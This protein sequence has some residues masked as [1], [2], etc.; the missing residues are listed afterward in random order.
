MRKR[1]SSRKQQIGILIFGIFALT[2]GALLFLKVSSSPNQEVEAIKNKQF[3]DFLLSMPQENGD[4]RT[5]RLDY[6][7]KE[8]DIDQTYYHLLIQDRLSL[9]ID[10]AKVKS[11]FEK[12]ALNKIKDDTYN[13][14][15]LSYI[16]QNNKNFKV[17]PRVLD[18]INQTYNKQLKLKLDEIN[19]E[20][21]YY[22]SKFKYYKYDEKNNEIIN[23]LGN[24]IEKEKMKENILVLTYWYYDLLELGF[25]ASPKQDIV[26]NKISQL[27]VFNTTKDPELIY[28]F[29][30]IKY[31][32]SKQFEL[33]VFVNESLKN[34]II[35]K[36]DARQIYYILEIKLLVGVEDEYKLLFNEYYKTFKAKDDHLYPSYVIEENNQV[37]KII[38]GILTG[39]LFDLEDNN[40][41]VSQSIMNDI[42][43]ESSLINSTRQ[44]YFEI[45]YC[46][47]NGK[48]YPEKKVNHLIKLLKDNKD[49]LENYYLY[50]SYNLL[51]FELNEEE[52]NQLYE[53][54]TVYSKEKDIAGIISLLDLWITFGFD[55]Q[56]AQVYWSKHID[57]LQQ[58]SNNMSLSLYY[59]FQILNYHFEKTIDDIDID[60]RFNIRNFENNLVIRGERGEMDLE[61]LYFYYCLKMGLQRNSLGEMK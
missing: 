32:I 28:Y 21:L 33:P 5:E 6:T 14:K 46:N 22:L 50:L 36:L 30:K 40:T 47:L 48:K 25:K 9:K 29:L 15:Y 31:H 49:F 8:G 45:L 58:E 3:F 19:I 44:I 35:F 37:E 11:S 39:E 59:H 2:L 38:W 34:Q 16:I 23:I 1:L 4:F 41:K 24:Y 52:K 55:E 27:D 56:V 10:N 61:T 20:E 13:I 60:K 57:D 12:Q 7:A 43:N 53:E 18:S 54:M 42:F 26:V 17:D 51:G